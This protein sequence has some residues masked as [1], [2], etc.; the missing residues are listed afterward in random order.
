MSTGASIFF[1]VL[2]VIG[3]MILLG[4]LI[5]YAVDTRGAILQAQQAQQECEGQYA[6][7][8]AQLK[9]AKDTISRLESNIQRLETQIQ[10][11]EQSLEKEGKDRQQAEAEV[12]QSRKR[13]QDL[14]QQL[15]GQKDLYQRT[16]SQT[17][18]LIQQ[19]DQLSRA[20][21]DAQEQNRVLHQQLQDIEQVDMV[22][23]TLSTW[24]G[25]GLDHKAALELVTIGLGSTVVSLYSWWHKG[26][27]RQPHLPHKPAASPASRSDVLVRMTRTQAFRY[28]QWAARGK[29]P[30]QS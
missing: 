6:Q 7:Q 26:W 4:I 17:G 16:L 1:T 8:N 3:L 12:E 24:V 20:L 10:G 15:A 9:V 27:K 21:N 29:L 11:L 30:P 13:L 19:I 22:L 18:S 28:A 5:Y 23:S 14:E 25:G 2:L